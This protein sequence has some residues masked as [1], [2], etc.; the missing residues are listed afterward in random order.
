MNEQPH[1]AGIAYCTK[2]DRVLLVRRA[3]EGSDYPNY[4]CFPGGGIELGESPDQA[5]KR[6][7][8]EE[9]GHAPQ[10]PMREVSNKDGFITYKVMVAQPFRVT[11][12]K[13]HT[14]YQ[15][16][17]LNALPELLH[18]GCADTLAKLNY[19]EKTMDKHI[20]IHIHRTTDADGPAHAPAGSP[21]GGQFVSGSGGSGGG[22]SGASGKKNGAPAQPPAQG[23]E[24]SYSKMKARFSKDPDSKIKLPDAVA[25]PINR[26]FNAL[27]GRVIEKHKTAA[28][29]DGIADLE[30]N[31]TRE[32]KQAYIPGSVGEKHQKNARTEIDGICK[33]WAVEI[34]Q[35]KKAI[36]ASRK[37]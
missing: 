3:R 24:E 28:K 12:N 26:K 2:D 19:R 31:G 22:K 29:K 6:E 8:Q 16:A 11:L 1:A 10:G 18:P 13:E 27:L 5:A 15:W 35:A 21:K 32:D 14:G 23:K 36:A 34:H 33:Q 25:H 9:I 4:W 20:H 7:S 30:T 37:T 17:S